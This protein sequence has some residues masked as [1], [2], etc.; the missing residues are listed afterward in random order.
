MSILIKVKEKAYRIKM[1]IMHPEKTICDFC[2]YQ[3]YR[4]AH[5]IP[6]KLYLKCLFRKYMKR[7][8]NLSH[9]LTFSE[10]LQWLK[11]YDRKPEYGI[12]ADKATV[13]QYVADKIG[14]DY[15][16]PTIGVFNSVDEISF[17]ELPERFVIK[18]TH[19]SGSTFVCSNKREF[20]FESVKMKL[21]EC[22]KTEYYWFGREWSYKNIK[23]RII[24]EEFIGDENGVCPVD[25]K[26]FCF[27][28]VMEY[29]KI[30]YNRFTNRAANYYDRKLEFQ[31]FGKIH[32][33]PDPSIQL[34]LPDNFDEMVRITQVLS[35]G[36]P[37]L[38]VDLYSVNSQ[39]YFGELTFYPSSGIEPFIGDGDSILGNKLQLPP[40][41][42]CR[43]KLCKT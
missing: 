35:K 42:R 5:L 2:E 10:K 33:T 29:F 3:N 18:C 14:S 11:L 23:P 30:D 24:V 40:K 20:D 22:L 12:M 38:R 31:H 26:F 25:Y 21:A 9:P 1:R 7:K 37:F 41:S 17:D 19:D 36:I 15:I 13:K 27:N 6:D 32:S 16:I 28:G 8:L 4:Y 34:V 39:V 43:R